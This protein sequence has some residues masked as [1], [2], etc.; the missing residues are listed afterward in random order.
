MSRG[1]RRPPNGSV[2]GVSNVT[3]KSAPERESSAERPYARLKGSRYM[4]A[5]PSEEL[6]AARIR[7]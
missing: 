1:R 6:Y 2:Y 7:R 3:T 4:T 5:V